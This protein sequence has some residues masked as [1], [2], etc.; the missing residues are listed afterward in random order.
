MFCATKPGLLCVCVSENYGKT[1][2]DVTNVINHTFIQTEFGIAV[3]PDHSGK[4]S[5][6]LRAKLID[7]ASCICVFFMIYIY[8]KIIKSFLFGFR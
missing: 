4:V 3:S 8:F 7:V 2:K 6:S 1:F 5:P